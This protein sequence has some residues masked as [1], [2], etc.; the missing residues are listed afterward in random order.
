MAII[1]K[2]TQPGNGQF[3]TLSGQIRIEQGSNRFVVQDVDSG[4][5]IAFG[6]TPDGF[7]AAYYDENGSLVKTETGKR[8]LRY[9]TDG[10]AYYI[11]GELPNGAKGDVY[12]KQ[13]RD[14]RDPS[15]YPA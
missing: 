15:I 6:R 10:S 2:I 7:G 8:E 9:R 5:I 12:V 3:S 14:A 11:S 4:A 13:G 1:T